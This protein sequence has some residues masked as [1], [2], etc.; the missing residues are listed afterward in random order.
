MIQHLNADRDGT[1]PMKRWI[2]IFEEA[3]SLSQDLVAHQPKPL[4]FLIL[5]AWCGLV[6]GLLE[7]AAIIVGKQLL[8]FNRLYWMSR[9]FVWIIPLINLF[10]FLSVGIVLA[11]VV[12]Y[13]WP[14]PVVRRSCLCVLTVL[15]VIWAVSNWII[16][17]AGFLMARGAVA[18]RLVPAYRAACHRFSK[19]GPGQLS[20][21][22]V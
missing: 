1:T 13:W 6:S 8:D 2:G 16:G 5:L 7:V 3:T 10:T 17:P 18:A 9:H 4:L 15:P 14:E 20:L 19:T 11:V 22:R 12:N 21:R